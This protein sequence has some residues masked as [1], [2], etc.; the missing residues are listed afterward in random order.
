MFSEFL[1]IIFRSIKLDKNLYIES[2]NYSEA[3]IYFAII[4]ILLTAIIGIVPGSAMLDFFSSSFKI[5]D[6]QGPSLRSVII[7]SL[8]VW[9]IK[10]AYLYFVGV[11]LFPSKSTKSSFRKILITVSYAHAPLI[12]NALIIDYRLLYLMFIPY[13]WYNIALIIGINEL[14][15]YKNYLKST[16]IVTAPI[17]LLLIFT[18]MQLSNFQ[19]G[20][21]S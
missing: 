4:L 15:K 8:I 7:T 9:L 19:I 12:F 16:L 3:S 1:N 14:L 6:L 17:I 21:V 10:T 20:V 13:I 18:I 11:V 2:K 5:N